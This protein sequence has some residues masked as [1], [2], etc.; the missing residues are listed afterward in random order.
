MRQTHATCG[1]LG[2][3]LVLVSQSVVEVHLKFESMP[4]YSLHTVRKVLPVT[5]RE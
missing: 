1:L 5:K 3:E 4:S 2:I